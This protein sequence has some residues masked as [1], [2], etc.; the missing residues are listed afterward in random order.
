[1]LRAFLLQLVPLKGT[2]R[3][4]NL[5]DAKIEQMRALK[6]PQFLAH[7]KQLPRGDHVPRL[8]PR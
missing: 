1:V 5:T 4:V 8:Q 6:I 2:A 3:G 7:P